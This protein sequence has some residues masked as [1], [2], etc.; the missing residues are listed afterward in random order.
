M[1]Q[2]VGLTFRLNSFKAVTRQTSRPPKRCFVVTSFLQ[3][4]VVDETIRALRVGFPD[5]SNTS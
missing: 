2:K 3:L 4:Q 1:M 5:S